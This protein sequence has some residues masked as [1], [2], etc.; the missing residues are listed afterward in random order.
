MSEDVDQASG[1][2]CR[3]SFNLDLLGLPSFAVSRDGKIKAWNKKL[4]ALSHISEYE[5]LH[6]FLS[7]MLHSDEDRHQWQRALGQCFEDN[8]PQKCTVHM[9]FW[10]NRSPFLIS[11]ASHSSEDSAVD[12]AVCFVEA[13][14][15]T[16]VHSQKGNESL[17][18][19][20]S[21]YCRIVERSDIATMGVDT[22]FSVFLWNEKMADISGVFKS[23]AVGKPMLDNLI[24]PCLRLPFEENCR[25]AFAGETT[26]NC[27][28]ELRTKCGKVKCL[29]SIITPY[30]DE[31]DAIG[32]AVVVAELCTNDEQRCKDVGLRQFIDT[33][34]ILIFGVDR[35][36]L[37][38]EWNNATADVIGFKD[39]DA[40]KKPL[41]E[42]F[43]PEGKRESMQYV[44]K[45]ALLGKGT[46]NYELEMIADSG[47]TRHLLV[48]AAV[49]RCPDSGV[50]GV[51][52][53]AH[54]ITE[55][56]KQ[57]RAVEAMANELR[58]LI[59][60]ANAPIFGINSDG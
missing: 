37:V 40:W 48:T 14:N 2:F 26:S 6:R 11:I 60:N 17:D 58:Q 56:L 53:I 55:A 30:M 36:G 59:D 8:D 9:K 29:R 51:I 13:H 12:G 22:D 31:N 21:D 42:A 32:G 38:N 35:N 57:D 28:F 23:E 25:K 41:I 46:S 39:T 18:L 34:T 47:E 45:E 1:G 16:T 52:Y 33:A 7:D 19:V 4:A 49:R 15:K 50:C 5:A 27:Y 20:N 43:V 3:T 44:Q 54:D 24:I 10:S